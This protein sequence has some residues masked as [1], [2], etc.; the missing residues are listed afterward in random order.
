M[1]QRG[2][3]MCETKIISVAGIRP[4]GRT[5]ASHKYIHCWSQIDAN[6]VMQNIYQICWRQAHY[7]HSKRSRCSLLQFGN[8]KVLLHIIMARIH[9]NE[10]NQA[11]VRHQPICCRLHHG[12][13]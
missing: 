2:T 8:N 1:L 3:K 11:G 12:E 9:P 4:L 13:P 5:P 7:W 6:S 10:K